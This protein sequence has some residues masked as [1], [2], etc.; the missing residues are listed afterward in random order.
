MPPVKASF[1][2]LDYHQIGHHHACQNGIKLGGRRNEA[3]IRSQRGKWQYGADYHYREGSRHQDRM[4]AAFE[5]IAAG[6]DDEDHQHLGGQGLDKP[7][8]LEQGFIGL[9]HGQH[10]IEGQ[11][12]ERR[13]D[14]ADHEHEI[15]DKFHVQDPWLAE[16]LG[17]PPHP[18]GSALRRDRTECC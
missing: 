11:E 2:H 4:G 3:E 14:G 17:D 9:Q 15:A 7:A 1:G 18:A 13:T 6:A 10:D 8:G 16:F 5:R 12:V